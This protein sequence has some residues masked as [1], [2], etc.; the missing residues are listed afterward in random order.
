M[1]KLPNCMALRICPL[2]PVR[3][4]SAASEAAAEVTQVLLPLLSAPAGIA[5]LH[6]RVNGCFTAE[7][8]ALSVRFKAIKWF[9]KGTIVLHFNVAGHCA[10][11]VNTEPP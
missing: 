10:K 3:D 7:P 1:S 4:V 8:L 9:L 6:L 2:V 11:S 5:S